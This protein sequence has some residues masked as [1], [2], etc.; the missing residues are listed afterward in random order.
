MVKSIVTVICCSNFGSRCILKV[1]LAFTTVKS[2]HII[3]QGRDDIDILRIMKDRIK[4][5]N[6]QCVA[7]NCMQD[8]LRYHPRFA[9]QALQRLADEWRVRVLTPQDIKSLV[10][11][12]FVSPVELPNTYVHSG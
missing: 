4:T 2:L 1:V 7:I 8:Q 10:N 6:I 5:A 11:H 12:G 3:M 9:D